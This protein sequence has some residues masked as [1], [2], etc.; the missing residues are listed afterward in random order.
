MND[1]AHTIAQDPT[2]WM[3]DFGIILAI[4]LVVVGPLVAGNLLFMKIMIDSFRQQ[5]TVTSDRLVNSINRMDD[6]LSVLIMLMMGNQ[7]GAKILT[8]KD[9]KDYLNNTKEKPPGEPGG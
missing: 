3:N 2:P 6:K 8:S 4:V 5:S 1:V 7:K 9:L